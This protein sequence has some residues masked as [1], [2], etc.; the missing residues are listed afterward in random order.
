[1]A[2]RCP[3]CLGSGQIKLRCE[4]NQKRAIRLRERGLSYREIGKVL[5][6]KSPNTIHYY[7]KK[8][9]NNGKEG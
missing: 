1:M 6:I 7:L 9:L 8:A 5:K 3:L 2:N 4:S